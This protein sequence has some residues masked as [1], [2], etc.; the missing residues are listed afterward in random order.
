MEKKDTNR[1]LF[2]LVGRL[3]YY[4]KFKAKGCDV[5]MCK[6]FDDH[7]KAGERKGEKRGERR[8]KQ[9]GLRQGIFVLIQDNM[10]NGTANEDIV[11]KLEKYFALDEKQAWKYIEQCKTTYARG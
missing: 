7:Y 4:E 9:W 3:E 10:V 6:A 8:G 11:Q 1:L 2:A 5:N